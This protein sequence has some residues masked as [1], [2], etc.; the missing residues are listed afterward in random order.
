MNL[1]EFYAQLF[2]PL[3]LRAAKPRTRQLYVTTIGN[4]SKF[5]ERPAKLEDLNDLAVNSYL[6]HFRDKGRS[7]YTVAKERDNLLAIWRFACRKDHL[8]EWPDVPRETLPENAPAAFLEHEMQSLMS[9]CRAVAGYVGDVLA[10]DFWTAIVLVIW[11][12]GERIGAVSEL[13]WSDVDLRE[14]WVNFRAETRKRGRK[15]MLHKLSEETVDVLER[16]KE[17]SKSEL[18]FAWPLSPTYLWDRFGVLLERA[19]IAKAN[20]KKFHAIRSS[21]ASY[22]EAAGGDATALLGHS[23]RKITRRHYLDPRIVPQTKPA[24]EAI[25][26][27]TAG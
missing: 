16:V 27:L 6:V 21:V 22:Y 11:D 14:R 19:G 13:R 5:L 7:P 12:T 8:K 2:V 9:V 15:F 1:Q 18:V 3:F 17:A 23:D 20:R 24:C 26:R 25:F 10:A 4:F